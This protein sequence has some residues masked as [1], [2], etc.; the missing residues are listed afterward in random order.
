MR[1]RAEK[2]RR[3]LLGVKNVKKVELIGVQAEKIYIEIENSKLARLGID[4]NL[5]ISTIKAQNAMTA[6][7]M[8]ETSSDNVYLR[9]SGLF[10]D[11]D[12]IRNLPIRAGRTFRLGDIAKVERGYG[13]PADPKMFVNGQP[14]IGI[15]LSMDKGG[16]ILAL[17]DDL[18]KTLARIKKDL[19]LGLE[20]SQV[21]NQPK[22]VEA[23]IGEFVQSLKEAIII[24]LIVS[25]LSLG[26]RSGVVVALC[27]PLVIAGV[28]AAMK[29]T[30][31]DLH[32]VS[33]GSLIIALGLLVD[34]AIIAIE[35]SR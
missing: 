10:D 32:K 27:I 33:L 11:L 6:S 24:V 2:I 21:A 29:M 20:I 13:E 28:F 31:I 23:S 5:I 26:V 19:P 7:G 9:V 25:F 30:G 18:E 17:G 3:Q 16:N 35:M 15:A 14:A 34:D 1:D 22:V 12:S 4:P 8:V